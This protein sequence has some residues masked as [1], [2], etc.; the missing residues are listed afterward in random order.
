[1]VMKPPLN[2]QPSRGEDGCEV[3]WSDLDLWPPKK[4]YN[5]LTVP[6]VST[7]VQNVKKFHRGFVTH[8][9]RRDGAEETTQRLT[10]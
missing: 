6:A 3:T 7:S 8:R 9:V 10:F 2:V 1:M 5:Q 4:K